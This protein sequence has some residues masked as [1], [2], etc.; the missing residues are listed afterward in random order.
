MAFY[1]CTTLETVIIKST[2]LTFEDEVFREC[3][4]LKEVQYYGTSEPTYNTES[5][6][7]KDVCPSDKSCS[8]FSC[9]TDSLTT[10][11]VPTDYTGPVDSFCGKAVTV[12]KTL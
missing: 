2:S 8:P 9:K 5:N 3:Y 6:C 4:E 7:E 11:Y 10:V 12:S 1:L